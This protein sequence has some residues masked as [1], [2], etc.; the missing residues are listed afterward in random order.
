MLVENEW[1]RLCSGAVHVLFLVSLCFTL[2]QCLYQVSMLRPYTLVFSMLGQDLAVLACW[3]GF[4]S[5]SSSRVG[6]WSHVDDNS[7]FSLYCPPLVIHT[8]VLYC[9]VTPVL[10]NKANWEMFEIS[11]WQPSFSDSGWLCVKLLCNDISVWQ[12]DSMWLCFESTED[13]TWLGH[14][15]IVCICLSVSL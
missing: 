6:D 14:A 7:G 4:I 2:Y 8:S 12:C 3:L 10:C 13:I 15:M 1:T 5:D 11:T 9:V